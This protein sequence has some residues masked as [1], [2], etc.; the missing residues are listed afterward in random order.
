MS[1]RVIFDGNLSEALSLKYGVKQGYV[2]IPTL[3]G[4]YILVLIH[5]FFPSPDG[6]T[7]CTWRDGKLFNLAYLKAKTKTNTDFIHELML[8][9]NSAFCAQT[10]S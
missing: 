3:F 4:I 5:C 7:L 2:M 9:D 6:V 10:E 8:A 1:A